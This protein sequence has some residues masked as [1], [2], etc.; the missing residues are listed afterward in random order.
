MDVNMRTEKFSK[1]LG[2]QTHPIT[3]EHRR[4]CELVHFGICTT[5]TNK[6]LTISN[7]CKA[8]MHYIFQLLQNP[9]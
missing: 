9:V 7:L 2:T 4:N 3:L 5:S 6:H 1:L 8:S